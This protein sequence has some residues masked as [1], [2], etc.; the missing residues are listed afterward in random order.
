L[1]NDRG[2]AVPLALVILV[3]LTALAAGLLT[4]GR[5]ESQI[6]SN[7]SASAQARLLAEAGLEYA[8]SGLAGQDF[9]AKL[10]AGPT[11]VPAGT[12]LPG[13]TATSG[14]FGVT[15]RNDIKNDSSVS[16]PQL[17]GLSTT[18][19][20]GTATIDANGAVILTSTG[21]YQGAARVIVAVV[22]RGG[23]G[24]NAALTL[25][26]VQADTTTDSPCPSGGC[27]PYPRNYSIDGR[28]WLRSDT[29][30]PSG[31]NPLKLGIATSS[32]MESTVEAGFSDSYRRNYVQGKHESAGGLTT[33]LSTI[34][35]DNSVTP[36]DIQK[37][38]TNLASNPA[39]QIL[40][41]TQA[42]QF[43]EG[44]GA[45]DKPEG[46]RL[47]STATANVVTVKNNCTG[48]AQINQTVNLGSPTSP[49]MIYIKGEF[50]PDSNFAG[51]AVDGTQSIQ[52]YGLLV[53]EDADL[54]FLQSGNFRWDGIVL[55]T[56]R[57]VAV[58]FKGDSRTEIRGALIGS[59]TNGS[60]SGGFF[61][62]YNR[63]TNTM[64]IRSSKQNVD[65]AL[66]ALYNMRMTTYRETCNG[67]S[68]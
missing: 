44:S 26:G 4:M 57:N 68:C 34:N 18:D 15:I 29:T 31:P 45:H 1:S 42:C 35:T 48:S 33:G 28:D 65:M 40:M 23:L 21:T 6:S 27:P 3:M 37:F 2:A 25:P 10:A 64:L 20:A 63:T 60:E 30:S 56:G 13:L 17:T 36:T 7:Q 16:D 47:T 43:P 24:I 32:T 61:E 11:L 59:E 8:F 67:Q 12:P 5:V 14:T 19:T 53:V 51:L 54:V 52:G 62:F 55:V 66:Q 58:A 41:S 49:Q 39:T 50:D 9:T 22:Q 38:M 46:L